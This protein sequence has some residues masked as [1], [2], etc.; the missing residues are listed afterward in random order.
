[1]SSGYQKDVARKFAVPYFNT[2]TATQSSRALRLVL[3]ESCTYAYP[4][5]INCRYQHNRFQLPDYRTFSNLASA[6]G[7]LLVSTQLTLTPFFCEAFVLSE[8]SAAHFLSIDF[9]AFSRERGAWN[10]L[11]WASES[12]VS[13]RS[14]SRNREKVRQVT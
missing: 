10:S 13:D 1:M 6:L 14:Y 8:Q 5:I 7:W 11:F 12:S 2:L 9:G 3:P 4:A